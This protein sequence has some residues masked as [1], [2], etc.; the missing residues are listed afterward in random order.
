MKSEATEM[1]LPWILQFSNA[2][3]S[4]WMFEIAID[5]DA[6]KR[7]LFEHPSAICMQKFLIDQTNRTQQSNNMKSSLALLA[8][9]AAVVANRRG[10][11]SPAVATTFVRAAFS[12]Q[13]AHDFESNMV[14][15]E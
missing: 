13:A 12:T 5:R 3:G 9:R 2:K 6:V 14:S 15:V 11:A 4:L 7:V 10:V 8:R 1:D